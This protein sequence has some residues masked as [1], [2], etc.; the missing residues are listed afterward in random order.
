MHV[1]ATL[2]PTS[3]LP[4]PPLPPPRYVGER[5]VASSQGVTHIGTEEYVVSA[6]YGCGDH[7]SLLDTCLV[8]AA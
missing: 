8:T 7:Q 5:P 3:L 2:P 4:H 6:V 1:A